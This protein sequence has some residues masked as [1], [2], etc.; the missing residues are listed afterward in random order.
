[1]NRYFL[2]DYENVNNKGLSGV[3]YLEEDDI[4]VIFYS[5]NANTLS[6]EMHQRILSSPAYFVYK[7]VN[8][9]EKNALDFQLASY[10]GYLLRDTTSQDNNDMNHYFIV[11]EDNG[12]LPI[13]K[14]WKT[15]G[16]TVHLIKDLAEPFLEDSRNSTGDFLKE[17]GFE[18]PTQITNDT[19]QI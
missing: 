11:T 10:L 5:K 18:F 17:Q 2:I 16:Y 6:F 7:K 9:G 3:Q 15:M 1:M 4:V 8:T 13:K 19:G 14:F 12:Y